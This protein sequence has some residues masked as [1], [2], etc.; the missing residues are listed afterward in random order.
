M[1]RSI[2]ATRICTRRRVTLVSRRLPS[3][4]PAKARQDRGGDQQAVIAQVQPR[5]T[6][7]IHDDPGDIHHQG[8][9]HPGGDEAFLGQARL[10]EKGA[11][12][13]PLMARQTPEKAAHHPAQGEIPGRQ[14]EGARRGASSNQGKDHHED[15][16]HQLHRHDVGFPAEN[17]V[18]EKRL[19]VG[20]IQEQPGPHEGGEDGGEAEF[21]DHGPSRRAGP[22]ASI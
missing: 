2:R 20:Q 1:A 19:E 17:L 12:Q 7:A 15:R 10:D 13:R 3:Q 6:D 14:G 8:D 16:H 22:G 4:A 5:Q 21:Q 18:M 9:D 11:A